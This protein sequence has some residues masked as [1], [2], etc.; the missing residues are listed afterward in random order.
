MEV[1]HRAP[2]TDDHI[3]RENICVC[4]NIQNDE[5]SLRN[6]YFKST[7]A[8]SENTIPKTF[9]TLILIRISTEF[10]SRIPESDRKKPQTRNVSQG[11]SLVYL[12]RRTYSI[13]KFW[14][15]IPIRYSAYQWSACHVSCQPLGMCHKS[16]NTR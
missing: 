15:R 10:R 6:R 5:I 12:L 7:L 8:S 1:M 16:I 3:G 14:Y 2:I 13:L 9:Q 4:N 11:R